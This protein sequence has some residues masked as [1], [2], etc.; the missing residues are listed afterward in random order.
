LNDVALVDVASHERDAL[1]QL[2][3]LYAYDF[4]ELLALDVGDDGRFPFRDLAPYWID[5]WRRPYFIRVNGALAGLALLH[6]RGY[7][8]ERPDVNDVSEFFVLRR[9]RRRG[10][11][12][13]AAALAFASLP[14]AWEVRV[15]APNVGAITF[16]RRVVDRYT[17]GELR[18]EQRDDEKWRGIV[19]RF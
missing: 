8:E 5:P 3:Q 2:I 17:R 1:Q 10:I 18:E 12:E 7:F 6:T 15:R 11:G 14:G 16:W 13:R 19:L 4:S 9:F